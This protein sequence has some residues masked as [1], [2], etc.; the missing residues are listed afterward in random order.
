LRSPL[1]LESGAAREQASKAAVKR[2]TAKVWNCIE[3][4]ATV[5]LRSFVE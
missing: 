3:R 1:F 2:V 5:F 4:R